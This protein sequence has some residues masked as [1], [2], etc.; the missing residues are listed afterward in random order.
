MARADRKGFEPPPPFQENDHHG[1]VVPKRTYTRD[2]LLMYVGYDRVRVQEALDGLTAESAAKVVPRAGVTFAEFLIGTLNHSQEHA[3]QLSLFL[4]Q[5][6]VEPP[7]GKMAERN[8]NI[9][10]ESV[11]FRTDAGI[12]AFAKMVGGYPRLLPLVFAGMCA[13]MKP[14]ADA[15]VVFDV[16]AT[17]PVK[18]TKGGKATVE[19]FT[20]D[21]VDATIT[22][23]P[24]DYLR[25]VIGELDQEDALAAGRMR[26]EG[27]KA[28][29][30]RF[31][32]MLGGR[33]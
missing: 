24:Q 21:D 4:G 22:M 2:E 29:L 9:L 23:T 3:A 15:V 27:D 19:K 1:N 18:V 31:F 20:P 26:L 5:H 17:F 6:G 10:R 12:D 25:W 8:R 28:A 13:N 11:R 7:G 14:R 30:K 16:G 32:S 33:R